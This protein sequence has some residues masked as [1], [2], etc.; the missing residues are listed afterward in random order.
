MNEYQV[1]DLQR[2]SAD[3]SAPF[4]LDM[5]SARQPGLWRCEKVLRTLPGK[6]WV[7]QM[8]QADSK[9]LA[10]VFFQ[11]R[12]Y[13]RELQGH[14]HLKDANIPTPAILEHYRV[15]RHNF[16]VILYQY[17]DAP[18]LE[19]LNLEQPL[20]ARSAAL[21]ETVRTAAAMHRQGLRQVDIHPGNFLYTGNSILVVDTAAIRRH[22]APLRNRLALHNLA[23]LLAQFL[24][25]QID[26]PTALW[27]HY[28]AAYSHV[29]WQL[30]QLETAIGKMRRLRWRHYRRKLTRNCSE[31]KHT[32]TF[33]RFAVWQRDS[34]GESLRAA[35]Q[36]PDAIMETGVYL[37]RGNTATVARNT[38]ADRE[39]ILKRYNIK[40]WRHRLARVWRPTRAWQSW[41]NAHYLLFYGLNTPRPYALLEERCGPLRGR[42][43][44]FCQF[45]EGIDL[46]Q[47][48]EQANDQQREALLQ[49]F[50]NILRAY[51]RAGIS[52]GDMKADNFIVND[53]GVT[54]IDLDPMKHHHRQATLLRALRRDI[55]RFYANFEA[56]MA[57]DLERELN[58]LLPAQLR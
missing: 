28:S 15:P 20:D 13:Q 36:Q 4:L 8:A 38:V 58:S 11:A 55:Q 23:D 2:A 34:D 14:Q 24:P 39:L 25:G 31:F 5:A 9:L 30:P 27:Q 19:Q 21:Q 1:E 16:H 42:G 26:D 6:R 7:L 37:K 43:F 35:L 40:N 22:K 12:D 48:L 17:I 47:A 44:F 52:H 10:K 54:I 18:T 51:Y 33:D 3:L 32:L 46:K 56:T 45:V 53:G 41:H 50:A 29:S 57:R 49:A